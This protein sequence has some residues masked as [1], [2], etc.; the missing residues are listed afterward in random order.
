MQN[1]N[2]G[3]ELVLLASIIAIIISENIS[4]EDLSILSSLFCAI[5]DNLA[6][7]ASKRT[8]NL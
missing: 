3:N 4:A 6:I 8:M 1:C 7:I 2:S 5:G